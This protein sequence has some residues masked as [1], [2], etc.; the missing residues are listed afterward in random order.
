MAYS[1]EVG[2][3]RYEL[4]R[5]ANK[6][7]KQAIEQGFWIEAIAICESLLSDRLESRL[8]HLGNHSEEARRQRTLGALVKIISNTDRKNGNEKLHEIYEEIRVWARKRNKAVH[9]AVKIS[10]GQSFETWEARYRR[11]EEAAVAGIDLFNRLKG[12]DAKVRRAERKA[13]AV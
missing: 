6:Q 10:D 3:A 2:H 4:Y 13:A 11:L 8:S 7:L 12:E 5:G 9:E 1:E